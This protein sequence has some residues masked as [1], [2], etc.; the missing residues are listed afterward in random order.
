[1][2]FK[3]PGDNYSSVLKH[4]LTLGGDGGAL[5]VIFF[6]ILS[7][8]LITYLMLREKELY[9]TLHIRYFYVRRILRIWP[10]YYLSIVA[11][12]IIYPLIMQEPLNELHEYQD[13]HFLLY[14]VFAA[15]FD[16]L[17]NPS[18]LNGI[19]GVQWSV[20]IEEQFYLIWPL[21]FYFFRNRNIF[22]FI[23]IAFCLLSEIIFLRTGNWAYGYY[24]FLTNIRFLSFGALLGYFCYYYGTNITRFFSRINPLV[25]AV[26]YVAGILLILF[27]RSLSLNSSYFSSIYHILPFVFFGFIIIEQ[28][29]SENSFFKIGKSGILSWLGKISYGLYLTHMIAITIVM[30]IFNPGEGY[31]ILKVFLTVLI[32]VAISFLSYKLFEERFLR[33]KD[34]FYNRGDSLTASQPA[35]QG[36]D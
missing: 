28:N 14:S 12:F 15:N 13:N 18:R 7:G 19:L 8:F 23:L 1:M 32:T 11:G 29:F 3:I 6:F 20:A 5:G 30:E 10:L 36:N 9:G 17:Y 34:R 26:I 16:N 27:N 24:H 31:F 25:H 2:W 4:M 35:V 22:P 21:V 33:F